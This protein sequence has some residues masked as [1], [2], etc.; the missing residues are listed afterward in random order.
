MIIWGGSFFDLGNYYL[1]TGGKYNPASNSWTVTATA[2]APIARDSHTAVWTGTE[3]IVWG[4]FGG[5]YLNTGGR[6]NPISDRW[7]PTGDTPSARALHAAVWTG[8][9]MIIW[10]GISPFGDP[11]PSTGANRRSEHGCLASYLQ[12]GY[13][14]RPTASYGRLDG[15]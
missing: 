9:E 10:S 4:G 8:S 11:Y 12:Y 2:N 13:T 6:Y 1:N 5:G 15:Y 14:D 7:L 3:M